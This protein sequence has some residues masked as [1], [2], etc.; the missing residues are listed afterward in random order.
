MNPS[1]LEE[2]KVL[3][4]EIEA[5]VKNVRNVEVA[6]CPPTIF[7]PFLSEI[8]TKR[9][10][11]GGQNVFWEEKGAYTGEIS[12]P[13]LKEFGCRYVIIGH[14]ER[15]KYFCETDETINLKI[16]AA[17]KSGLKIILCAGETERDTSEKEV[18][19]IL[20][21]QL[22]RALEGVG[23]GRLNALSIAY[24][25]LWAISTSAT[26]QMVTPDDALKAKLFIRKLLMKLYDRSSAERVRIL[27][28]GSVNSKNIAGFADV[29]D[30]ALVGAASL[31]AA[32]FAK[33]VKISSLC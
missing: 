28:G 29:M 23:K 5:G 8:K 32:E 6:V 30:G 18:A 1:S 16:K 20:E 24:E 21:T 2:A 7:L 27:Y 3:L 4:K 11:R 13:M 17:L 25:P 33:I 19:H 22:R 14:S 15:K 9:I 26:G 12:C 10:A 31:D